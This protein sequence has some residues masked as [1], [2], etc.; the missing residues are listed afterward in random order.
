M[1]QG[2]QGSRPPGPPGAPQIC[3]AGGHFAFRVTPAVNAGN[4]FVF[5][6]HYK[7]PRDAG[8]GAKKFVLNVAVTE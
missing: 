5:E 2:Y 7:R 6:A 3:G 8:E 4:S 1:E